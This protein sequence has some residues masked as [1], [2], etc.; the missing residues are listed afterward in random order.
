MALQLV[1]VAEAASRLAV[2][3]DTVR[4]LIARGELR[5]AKF[6][7]NVRIEEGELV[8]LVRRRGGGTADQIGQITPGQIRA[9]HAKASRLDTELGKPPRTAK[10]AILTM[11]SE[12]FKRPITSTLELNELEAHWV[13]EKL[14]DELEQALS[15]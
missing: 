3:E 6:G 10:K 5:A 15:A 7:R 8:A 11:A 12:Q 4:R 1:T 14:D 9:L 2:H 13:L